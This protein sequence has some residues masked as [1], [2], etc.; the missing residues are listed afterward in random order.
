MSL[1]RKMNFE[2]WISMPLMNYL[3]WPLGVA[4]VKGQ[5]HSSKGKK[6]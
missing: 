3:I 6:K 4:A 2:T 5:L 1:S